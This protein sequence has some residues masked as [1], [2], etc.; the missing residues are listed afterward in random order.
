MGFICL[1]VAFKAV[2]PA[3]TVRGCEWTEKRGEHIRL[4]EGFVYAVCSIAFRLGITL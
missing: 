1:H 4:F 2:K 3:E